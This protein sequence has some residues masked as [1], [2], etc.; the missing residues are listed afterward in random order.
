ME[1]WWKLVDN[2]WKLVEHKTGE[3]LFSTVFQ[4]FL[5]ISPIPPMVELVENWWENCGQILGARIEKHFVQH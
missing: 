3:L 1:K 2:C 4:G 5:E